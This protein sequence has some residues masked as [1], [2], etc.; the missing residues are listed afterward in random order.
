MVLKTTWRDRDSASGVPSARYRS[1][2]GCEINKWR[3]RDI[4]AQR[5]RRFAVPAAIA[6]SAFRN[7][8]QNR[9]FHLS[10]WFRLRSGKR[11]TARE[12]LEGRV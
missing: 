11:A 5:A 4:V 7:D 2:R 3:H 10:A 1:L 6:A 12:L 9:S 8:D